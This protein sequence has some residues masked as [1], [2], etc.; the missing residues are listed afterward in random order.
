MIGSN[1]GKFKGKDNPVEWV[2]WDDA[3][4]FCKKLSEQT[5]QSIRLPTEAEW[6]YSCRAGTKTTYHSG[7]SDKD[8]DRVAW[9]EVNSKR[10]IHPVGQ[11]EPNTFGLYD[12]HGNVWQW[13][14]D[15][16]DEKYYSKSP[17]ENPQSRDRGYFRSV[18]GGS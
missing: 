9:Y 17:T 4:A 6:E 1:P 15:L 14:E 7:D 13:C 12:M 5:K 8:L 10:T 18:R 11:K 2:S 16:W 3:Q